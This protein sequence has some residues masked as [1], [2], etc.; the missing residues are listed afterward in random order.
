[1]RCPAA[2]YSE[3]APAAEVLR[4]CAEHGLPA[5][6]DRHGNILARVR[7]GPKTQPAILA[8]HL[9]HPGFALKK[10][11]SPGLWSAEFLGGVGDAYFKPGVKL[12]A[13]P[14][15]SKAVLGAR[16]RKRVFELRTEAPKP[17]FA[18]WDLPEFQRAHGLI[19]GRAC[20]DLIGAACILA[21]LAELQR[22]RR[23]CDAIGVFSRAEEVGFHGALALAQTGELP[24]E[25]LLISLETSREL[26]PVKMGS[27]VIVRV[28]DR[29]STF[30]SAS[31]RYLAELAG[32]LA[33]KNLAFRFQRALM[34]GGTCEASAYQERGYRCAAVCVALGNYHNCGKNDRIRA[35]FVSETDAL[36]MVRL[37]IEAA[38]NMHRFEALAG[39][40]PKR[41]ERLER[42]AQ[43]RLRAPFP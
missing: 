38:R 14:G 17:E 20:D 16:L 43:R 22:G 21:S 5:Q 7:H 4:I 15:G 6:L 25:S 26:P 32:D 19:A 37:M 29:S 27:G 24:K 13:Y 35:E 10:R 39:R 34:G 3:Q 12:R 2:P 36:D 1:M 23:R 28:G 9:D 42:A 30:D 41:L 31:T 8:A 40:L 11:L 33:K 18:V